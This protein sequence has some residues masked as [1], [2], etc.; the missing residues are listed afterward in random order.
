MPIEFRD[1]EGLRWTVEHRIKPAA[2]GPRQAVIDLVCESGE[3]RVCEVLPLE[4]GAWEHVNEGAWRALLR[5]ARVVRD[6]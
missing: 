3:H 1:E 5:R 2:G 6:R 4:N